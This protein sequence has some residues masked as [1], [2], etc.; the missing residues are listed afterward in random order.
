MRTGILYFLCLSFMIFTSCEFS[1]T[2]VL[3]TDGSGEMKIQMDASDMISM[4]SAMGEQDEMKEMDEQIDTTFFFRDFLIDKKDS[5]ANLPLEQQA[6]L[7][8]LEPY[9]I[10]INMDAKEEKLVYDVFIKFDNI[11]EANNMFDVFNQISNTGVN[12]STSSG[13]S[14]KQE[15]IK[16]NYSFEK[17]VFKRDAFIADK[18]LHQREL[19]SLKSM[20]MMLA[21]TLYKLN[22]SFPKKIKSTSQPEATFSSDRKTLYFQTEYLEYLKN[23]DLLDIEVVLENQ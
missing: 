15:S 23:P 22:Y 8:K 11:T 7:K 4:M 18:I 17:N 10:H 13:R 1:E 16:V 14:I 20:E 5:I 3:N 21:G 12:S 9:G 2:L 19:D 6:K